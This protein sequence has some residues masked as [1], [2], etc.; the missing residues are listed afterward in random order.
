MTEVGDRG[1]AA[2]VMTNSASVER[3]TGRLD[4]AM[5]FCQEALDIYS[6][7]KDRWGEGCVMRILG[8]LESDLGRVANADERLAKALATNERVKNATGGGITHMNLALNAFRSNRAREAVEHSR[9]AQAIF[10]TVGAPRYR[11]HA[12]GI[13]AWS[14][15]L[16]GRAADAITVAGD[17]EQDPSPETAL[18]AAAALATAAFKQGDVGA[19]ADA[20]RTLAEEARA[21]TQS[22]G[23]MY[24]FRHLRAFALSGLVATGHGPVDDAAAAYREALDACAAPG[25]IAGELVCLGILAGDAESLAPIRDLLRTGRAA[26]QVMPGQ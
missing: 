15:L 19:A 10:A 4:A 16:I 14:A 2:Y 3:I 25:V 13:A 18:P 6:A 7:I 24:A 8:L 11:R 22:A 20:F 12:N 5:T 21:R 23:D 9:A 26:A 17:V 1:G